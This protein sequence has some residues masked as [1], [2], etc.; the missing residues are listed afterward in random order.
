MVFWDLAYRCGR[1]FGHSESILLPLRSAWKLMEKSSSVGETNV[2]HMSLGHIT[3]YS[4]NLADATVIVRSTERHVLSF[5]NPALP[6]CFM[7]FCLDL[8]TVGPKPA[9]YHSHGPDWKIHHRPPPS[10]A[11]RTCTKSVDRKEKDP[12]GHWTCQFALKWVDIYV[13]IYYVY[14][15]L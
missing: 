6:K 11:Y 1:S 7:V 2:Q 14:I 9:A 12:H 8:S 4:S 5:G 10:V 3:L 15:I 13:Y